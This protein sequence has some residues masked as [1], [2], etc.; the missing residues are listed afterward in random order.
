MQKK[1]IEKMDYQPR[2]YVGSPNQSETYWN[3]GIW[4]RI[5]EPEG[6]IRLPRAGET[7][8]LWAE[9]HN[10]ADLSFEDVSVDFY[11]KPAGADLGRLGA[12]LIGTSSLTIENGEVRDVL[13]I[14][15]WQPTLDQAGHGCLVV[16]L[17]H[18]DIPAANSIHFDAL[19]TPWVGQRNVN[20]IGAFDGYDEEFFFDVGPYKEDELITLV[21]SLKS[22]EEL[23]VLSEKSGID[24]S[25]MSPI[26][27]VQIELDFQHP[28]SDQVSPLQVELG[29]PATDVAVGKLS[30][31]IGNTGGL[32][33]IAAV[34]VEQFMRDRRVGGFVKL[35][36]T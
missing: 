14:N 29:L 26:A 34:S 31:S 20:I 9:I 13:C 4:S 23:L 24:P 3:S 7:A 11:F 28:N 17:R 27:D 21:A 35:I 19:S 1:M 30:V 15:P 2:I 12:I 25:G 8:F 5:G 36:T 18:A 32:N 22:Q 10:Y 16:E 33:R 6:T